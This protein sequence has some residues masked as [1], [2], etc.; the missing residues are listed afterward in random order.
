M[1]PLCAEQ[2]INCIGG[3]VS[4][5]RKHGDV[6]LAKILRNLSIWTRTLQSEIDVALETDDINMLSSFTKSPSL[7]IKPN[8]VIDEVTTSC[9]GN[10][11]KYYDYKFWEGH[12]V[13]LTEITLSSQDSDLLVELLGTLNNLTVYDL[14]KNKT[15]W[16][17]ISEF[18][19]TTF[20]AKLLMP[21]MEKDDVKL[22][23]L[24][25]CGEMC[26]DRSSALH[27]SNSV[28][29]GYIHNLWSISDD[30]EFALQLLCVYQRFLRF[31]ETRDVIML[32]P[33][34]FLPLPTCNP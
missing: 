12:V 20:A 10:V 13:H 30:N 6:L 34:K 22:E 8:Y 11:S 15:W 16:D 4:R 25:L 9:G 18:S 19:L 33:G 24:I 1:D 27:F 5:L 7:F 17:H 28:L 2:M 21:E 31:D 26:A 3:L 32:D 23:T 14:P 29:L